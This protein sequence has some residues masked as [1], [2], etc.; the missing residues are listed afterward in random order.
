M[1][2][3]E[4]I[5]DVSLSMDVRFVPKADSALMPL[6]VDRSLTFG[7]LRLVKLALGCCQVLLCLNMRYPMKMPTIT[8]TAPVI[9]AHAGATLILSVLPGNWMRHF[10][11]SLPLSRHV[12][13]RYGASAICV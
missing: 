6:L 11:E 8:S 12:E 2:A 7:T 13:L 1:T 5:A 3:F 4:G 9:H 10:R